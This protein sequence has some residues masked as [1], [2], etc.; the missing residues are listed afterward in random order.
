MAITTGVFNGTGIGIYIGAT[1]VLYGTSHTIS[2]SAAERD[3]TNKDTVGW[4]STARGLLSA[5]VTAEH[6]FAQDAAYGYKELYAAMIAGTELSVELGNQ[7]SG[8]YEHAGTFVI[9]NLEFTA[10][11]QENT[12]YSATFRNVGAVTYTAIV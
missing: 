6:L 10:P 8:D 12:T 9:T 2:I 4:S 5:N 3:T 7:N 11:N 1:L